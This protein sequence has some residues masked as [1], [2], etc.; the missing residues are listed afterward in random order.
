M[1]TLY[2]ANH[3][4]ILCV[5]TLS[6]ITLST[7]IGYLDLF[8]DILYADTEIIH[9]VYLNLRSELGGGP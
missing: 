6:S 1:N 4:K 5:S 2:A 7:L 9:I 8:F 3:W